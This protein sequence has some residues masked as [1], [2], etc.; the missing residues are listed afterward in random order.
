MSELINFWNLILESNTFNFIVLLVLIVIVMQKLHIKEAV[1]KLKNDIVY[2]IESSKLAKENAHKH[3]AEAKSKIEH[4]EDEI[5]E[6]LALA[7][8]QAG[9]AAASIA[10]NIERKVRQ[11][12]N[13]TIKVI[14]AEEKTL[15]TNLTADISRR[16]VKLASNYIKLMF[17]KA[18]QLHNKYIEES[19]NELDKVRI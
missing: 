8:K 5:S 6:K 14:E 18:P 11:I 9:N 19:I 16:A 1:E 3:L 10:E 15:V 4:I 2:E 13:N 17:E 12:E 7:S